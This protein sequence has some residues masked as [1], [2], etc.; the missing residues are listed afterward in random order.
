MNNNEY[1]TPDDGDHIR[2]RITYHEAGHCVAALVFDIPIIRVTIEADVPHL[3][4]GRW[5]SESDMALANIVTLCLC[6]PAAEIA[7]VGP[8][9]DDSD[10]VDYAMARKYLSEGGFDPVLIEVEIDKCR[11][12]ANGLVRTPWAQD[13]IQLIAAALLKRGSL[14]G[15]QIF[16]LSATVS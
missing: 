13:R 16:E 8:I 10:H 14:S 4:R 12:A 3:H 15:E 7:Y 1:Y 9:C 11:D 2:E 6:G 5:R